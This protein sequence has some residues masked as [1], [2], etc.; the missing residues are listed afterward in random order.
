MTRLR[1]LAAA[2]LFAIA[3]PV[4]PAAEPAGDD[5]PHLV[6]VTA[7]RGYG[8]EETLPAFAREHLSDDFRITHVHS[9]PVEGRNDLEGIEALK[10]ADLLML[11]VRRRAPLKEQMQIIREYV[12][13]GK[14]VVAIRSASHAF[15]LRGEEPP[16]GHATWESFDAE[17]LGGNYHGNYGQSPNPG[18]PIRI[19]TADGAADHPILTGVETPFRSDNALYKTAPLAEA[20]T[21]LLV[22][23]YKD[24]PAQPVAWTH[25]SPAGG[26]VFYVA[27][28]H[29]T[30]FNNQ[31]FQRLLRNGAYW[32][33][34]KEIPATATKSDAED[35]PHLV[36]LTAEREYQ[37]QE[38][39]PA[40]ARNHLDD[41][42]RIT[43][44]RHDPARGRHDLQGIEA[45]K[46]ADILL[47]SVRRRAPLKEQM[48]IIRDYVASGKPV[49]GIRTASHAFSLRGDPPPPGHATWESF[50]AEVIGGNYHDH[51]GDAPPARITKAEGAADHPIL[52]GVD[53]PFRAGG[54]LYKNAPIQEAATPL[55]IGAI[56]GHPP[57]PVAWT[58]TTPAGGRVFYTSL[59]HPDDF[60]KQPFQRLL[61]NGIYWAA[62]MDAKAAPE[63][64]GDGG[65]A[66]GDGSAEASEET[67]KT[68]ADLEV[69]TVL[70]KPVIA[71]P[72]Y[73]TF[74]E[75]GRLWVVEYRQ[76]P[77]PAGLEPASRD[78][79][80]RTV[81]DRALPPPPYEKDSPYRGK[82][83]ITIHEDTDGDGTFDRHKTF[84]DGLN[85]TTAALPGRGGVWVLSPPQLLFYPDRNSD[86]VPDSKPEVH[87]IGFG[88]E[89]TH[90]VA[91]SLRWGPDG[92]IYGAQGSTVSAAITRPGGDAEPI[93][94]RGQLV[95]RYHPRTRRYEVFA[96][97]GG[98]A[99]GVE[100]DTKGRTFSGHNGGDTRGFHYAQG[101]YYQKN[102][103]KHAPLS[104]PYAFGY[105][106]PMPAA[107]DIPRFTH[108]FVVYGGGA[109]PER[110]EGKLFA[111]SPLLNRVVCSE[112]FPYGS[113]FRTRDIGYALESDEK[114]F[115]PVDIKVGPDGA[116]YI[117]DF[118]ERYI[119]H[120]DHFAGRI[121]KDTGRIYRLRAK[122]AEPIEPFDLSRKSSDELVDLLRHENRWFRRMALRLL[123]D[124]RN[125]AVAPRLRRIIRE[126]EGQFALEALWALNLCGGFHTETAMR[127][128]EHPNPHVRRWTVRLLCDEGEVSE[129]IAVQLAE[130]AAREPDAGVRMQLACSAR[131]LPAQQALPI[132]RRLLRREK[133][134][135]DPHIPLLLWWAIEA[136]CGPAP[137]AVLAL[138]ESQAL[139]DEP[140][141]REHI[142]A[143]LMRRFA[144][145]GRR[146]DL[147]RCA[148]L[149]EMAP[150][151]GST[152]RLMQGFEKAFEGRGIGSLPD[153][154][155]EALAKAGG[156]SLLLR[157]RRGNAQAVQESLA[158]I[159][160]PK[161]KLE[162]RI[163]LVRAFGEVKQ[164]QA[165]PVLL[166]L[167]RDQ[168]AHASQDSVSEQSKLENQKSRIHPTPPSL[169]KE[170]LASLQSY[171][172]PA[173]GTAVM[174]LYPRMHESIQPAAA[175]LLSS[176]PEWALQMLNAIEVGAIDSGSVSAAAVRKLGLHED[177]RV[178]RMVREQ[179]R[180]ERPA[181]QPAVRERVV[182]LA[183][184]VRSK[185]GDPYAGKEIFTQRCAACHTLFGR[186]GDIGPALT[187]YNRDD[188]ERMLTNIVA[189]SAEVREGFQSF[190]ATT[191]DGRVA[192]GFLVDRDE[193]VVVL[194][195]MDGQNATLRRDRITKMN[196]LGRSLMPD[197][198]L[199]G[200]TDQQ[201]RNLFAYLRSAQPLNE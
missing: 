70:S 19:T 49:V 39:L 74:D 129:R 111:L 56:E 63:K 79:Y 116:I 124:R 16:P 130:V 136:K 54:T 181:A 26:R 174:R 118:H 52:T 46:T 20:A 115:R 48:R 122:D 197:A 67:W 6:I 62:E 88:I 13:S 164:P 47:L 147:R 160:D 81:W 4:S 11:S 127:A 41:D 34:G 154:L 23:T 58:H 150:D 5:R 9:E 145:T 22:G 161:A 93:R 45:M 29:R 128:L 187:D 185:S 24:S 158:I 173:I 191:K 60:K 43:H 53:T 170:A 14:P 8:T 25:T 168:T 114:S 84:L 12:A 7:E 105:F 107:S 31:P 83:R 139:W 97:G 66:T 110:Y 91:N 180:Q 32:A 1:T 21:P 57:Q 190:S 200:L 166:D 201:V 142:L 175:M 141:V 171:G 167:L 192:T 119:A 3:A 125:E 100:I 27:L 86:D 65:A 163:Q 30:D 120:H 101:G 159:A 123:G 177:Q 68:F 72:V 179:F 184:V 78:E 61:R 132:V 51:Y 198:L 98:N 121:A 55:L 112:R 15:S 186:G 189:P 106:P 131:R 18:P 75:R 143:R 38:T 172:E 165:I 99:F 59:G 144:E 152:D 137:G 126:H 44:I 73:M 157:V 35:A 104:N 193:N 2:C 109:L 134:A 82:D 94:S 188:V 183:R 64:P 199:N 92:W 135:D 28:S 37:T 96:E 71:Q 17:I 113:T 162:R 95:W 69:E 156:G 80:L 140:M 103:T 194:R 133:D 153:G 196:P 178:A 195:G 138:F 85:I 108:T 155:V 102:F 87:L 176:R 146:A 117:A 182:R 149:F 76:Y 33:A 10:A 42:F 77:E 40:F 151:K 50:D 90:A 148:K 36:I 89:D 169:R